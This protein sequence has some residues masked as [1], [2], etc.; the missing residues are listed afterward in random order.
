MVTR[1]T[2]GDIDHIRIR[3]DNTGDFAGWYLYRVRVRVV[4]TDTYEEWVF[5][6]DRWLDEDEAD[7]RISAEFPPN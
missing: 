5:T 4:N 7:G 2:V 3:H 6:A 1:E